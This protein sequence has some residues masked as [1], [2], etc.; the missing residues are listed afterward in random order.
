MSASDPKLCCCPFVLHR[1]EGGDLIVGAFKHRGDVAYFYGV[2]AER[3]KSFKEPVLPAR[4]EE[5][6]TWLTVKVSS[7]MVRSI[8]VLENTESAKLLDNFEAI[9]KLTSIFKAVKL[10][11]A[12]VTAKW[13][14]QSSFATVVKTVVTAAEGRERAGD[15]ER[16]SSAWEE[17]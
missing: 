1:S 3:V 5:E 12:K 16:R 2:P 4:F 8:S 9:M 17:R 6:S 11:S 7:A 10:I 15:A 14:G 13:V